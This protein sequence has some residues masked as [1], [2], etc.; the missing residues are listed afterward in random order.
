MAGVEFQSVLWTHCPRIPPHNGPASGRVSR[1]VK[2]GAA[3]R[4]GQEG[5][6]TLAMAREWALMV[7]R[8]PLTAVAMG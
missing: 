2:G 5:Q 8:Q 4:R 7:C 6:C 3:G 1:L